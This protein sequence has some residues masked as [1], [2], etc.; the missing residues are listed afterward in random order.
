MLD[1]YL[2]GQ[3]FIS[4]IQNVKVK[5]YQ[6]NCLQNFKTP[7]GYVGVSGLPWKEAQSRDCR[8]KKQMSHACTTKYRA[9]DDLPFLKL[10]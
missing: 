2:L 1:I 4:K 6:N 8:I 10:H 3:Y 9:E 5:M 7:P